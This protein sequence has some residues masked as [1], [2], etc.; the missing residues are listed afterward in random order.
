[1]SHNGLVELCG[2]FFTEIRINPPYECLF[3]ICLGS[4][5]HFSVY[6]AN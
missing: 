4:N 1:M 2:R 6:E 5:I 3:P